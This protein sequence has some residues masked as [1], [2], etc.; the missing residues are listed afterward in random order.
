[1]PK[2]EIYQATVSESICELNIPSL[3][4]G[5]AEATFDAED[6]VGQGWHLADKVANLVMGEI[7]ADQVFIIRFSKD[8]K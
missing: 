4:K 2:L 8:D 1:M 6:V 7:P 3:Q 5:E